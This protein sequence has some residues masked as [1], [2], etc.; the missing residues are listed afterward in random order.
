MLLPAIGVYIAAASSSWHKIN[1]KAAAATF[2]LPGCL[3]ILLFFFFLQEGPSEKDPT[4]WWMSA[5]SG[6]D[7]L[8]TARVLLGGDQFRWPWWVVANTIPAL[9]NGIVTFLN[10]EWDIVILL[11]F[12][13]GLLP[14]SN[15][16]RSL[17]C[18]AAAIVFWGQ[19]FIYSAF[20]LP[21]LIDRTALPGM[22]P[23]A[24]FLGIAIGTLR[25]QKLKL[26]VFAGLV[27]MCLLFTAS[28]IRKDAGKPVE[29]WDEI[30]QSLESTS[31]SADMILLYPDYVKSPL[32]YYIDLPPETA[33]PIPYDS[34][35]TQV[36][37]A[38]KARFS[39]LEEGDAPNLFLIVR[40]RADERSQLEN[41]QQL[42]TYLESEF[43]EPTLLKQFDHLSLA[44]YEFHR[45]KP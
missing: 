40:L 25:W 19:L 44:K 36:E 1:F 34:D 6:N 24:G 28:W 15:W 8:F 10:Q 18:L 2:M 33:L 29:A 45:E 9:N 11:I 17:P 26:A 31:H 35:M 32:K 21:I 16:R 7:L 5:P 38:I 43:G 39:Q 3:F 27:L 42:V 14:L 30:S 41:Y 23:F 37:Q 4:T 12:F 22:V 13:L 20:V